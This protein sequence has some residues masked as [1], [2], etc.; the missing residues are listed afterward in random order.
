[1]SRREDGSGP[2]GPGQSALFV[3]DG[4]I[5][6]LGVKSPVVGRAVPSVTVGTS[7][8]SASRQRMTM[9]DAETA[10]TVEVASKNTGHSFEMTLVVLYPTRFPH[11]SPEESKV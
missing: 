5:E 3:Q 8:K 6:V 9:C 10:R 11:C 4:D 7:L 1:M 2:S